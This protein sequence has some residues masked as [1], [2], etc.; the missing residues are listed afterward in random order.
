MIKELTKS[1]NFGNK[2]LKHITRTSD[3]EGNL[4][5][6]RRLSRTHKPDSLPGPVPMM[7][8][9]SLSGTEIN[10]KQESFLHFHRFL[11][12]QW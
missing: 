6:E 10:N 5:Y 11:C 12:R 4:D 8:T 2:R 7:Y 3:I 1:T 9:M